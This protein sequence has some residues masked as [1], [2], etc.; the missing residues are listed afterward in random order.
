[1]GWSY[2]G[3]VLPLLSQNQFQRI[4][5]ERI[6]GSG[7]NYNLGRVFWSSDVAWER[8]FSQRVEQ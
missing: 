7:W 4:A 5:D 6:V 3:L 2:G 1:M 8:K